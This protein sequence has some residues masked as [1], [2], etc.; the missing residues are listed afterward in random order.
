MTFLPLPA[1]A[2]CLPEIR[3]QTQLGSAGLLEHFHD[4]CRL[5]QGH[6]PGHHLRV[7]RAV[8]MAAI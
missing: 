1:N 7:V 3:T 6:D 8:H 4:A 5:H 2:R